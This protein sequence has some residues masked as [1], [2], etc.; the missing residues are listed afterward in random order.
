M[1]FLLFLVDDRRIRVRIHIFDLWIWM[2]IRE[3][4]KNLDP[5][6]RIRIRY[7]V[8]K[9]WSLYLACLSSLAAASLS[10]STVSAKLSPWNSILALPT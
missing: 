1:F 5:I 2:R 6:L 8:R 10:S 7:T 3:S 9:H 4:Q